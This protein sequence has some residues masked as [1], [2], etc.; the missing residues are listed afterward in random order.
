[1]E[2]STKV[3]IAANLLLM[4]FFNVAADIVMWLK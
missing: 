2:K 3:F 4:A 1:M